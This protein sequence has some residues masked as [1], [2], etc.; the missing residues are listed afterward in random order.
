MLFSYQPDFLNNYP[1]NHAIISLIEIIRNALDNCNFA[2]GVFIDLGKAFD[3]V[4]HDI[5][6]SKLNHYGIRGV[7]FDCLKSYHKDRN[8]YRTINNKRSEI[9]TIKYGV[10]QGS[11]PEPLLF[12]IYINDLSL[13]LE[14]SNI[15]HFADDTDVLHAS[16][17]LRD[18]DTKTNFDLSNLVQWLQANKV[19]LNVTT[20]DTVI[21][22]SPR[23]QITR[24]INFCL[25]G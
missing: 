18:I 22:R 20:T 9:Q 8:Q 5:L 14:N 11:I 2:C 19:A 12:L 1:T 23:Y 3:T 7:T 16:N 17:Y 4:N 10:P 21:F 13:S 6:L 25:S 24:K 15:H